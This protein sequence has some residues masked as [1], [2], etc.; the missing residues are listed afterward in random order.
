[1]GVHV[2]VD[3]P[4]HHGALAAI[5]HLGLRRLD[6]L[7]RH[8]LDGIA[9][10]Q[11]FVAAARFFP[12]R[13]EEAQVLEQKRHQLLSEVRRRERHRVVLSAAKDLIAAC[14]RHEIFRCASARSLL[15]A[16]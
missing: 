12:M 15:R 2:A 6:R 10:D 11:H 8:L 16:R 14:N 7:G 9:L 13:I 3:Q 4:R 5:H 1:M